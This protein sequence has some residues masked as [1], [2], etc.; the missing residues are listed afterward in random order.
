MART[1]AKTKKAAPPAKAVAKDV[2][3]AK[4][5]APKPTNGVAAVAKDAKKPAAPAKDKDRDEALKV[6][7]KAVAKP[8]G[9]AAGK[10]AARP[11][12][13]D[14]DGEDDDFGDDDDEDFSMPKV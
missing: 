14:L 11:P 5:D 3:V 2:K 7:A 9:K 4:K 13:N 1:E 12:V 10:Q 8:A 6:L